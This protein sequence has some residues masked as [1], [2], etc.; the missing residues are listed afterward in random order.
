MT[1]QIL[2]SRGKMAALGPAI[3]V[4]ATE[5]AHALSHLCRFT[6]H[7]RVFYSVG[8]HTYTMARLVS[9]HCPEMRLAALLHDGAE[10]Y[11]GDVSTPLKAM[12]PDYQRLEREVEAAIVDRY[13][14]DFH[15]PWLKMLDRAMCEVERSAF[16]PPNRDWGMV[17]DRV[18]FTFPDGYKVTVRVPR[19]LDPPDVV[20]YKWLRLHDKLCYITGRPHLVTKVRPTM[21]I[22]KYV[23][24]QRAEVWARNRERRRLRAERARIG[25]IRPRPVLSL[26]TG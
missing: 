6:G 20:R 1:P 3:Q 23:E 9:P 12:L 16:L 14:I 2:T 15:Q 11:L 17:G 8:H 7:T 18:H 13:E 21:E 26:P 24:Q 22:R 5:I 4:D 10:A 25:D 19:T